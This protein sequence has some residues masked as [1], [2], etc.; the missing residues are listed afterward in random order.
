MK[1]TPGPW[2][3]ERDR[4]IPVD[5]TRI[6]SVVADLGAGVMVRSLDAAD[7][8]ILGLDAECEANKRLIAAAPEL[9]EAL[10]LV[11]SYPAVRNALEP[12]HNDQACAAIKKAEAA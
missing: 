6:I 8:N 4:I 9:L 2:R 10:K 11:M 5:E 12:E 7:F 3:V 1:H